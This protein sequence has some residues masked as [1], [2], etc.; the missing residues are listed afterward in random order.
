MSPQGQL[1]EEP[2][3]AKSAANRVSNLVGRGM[4]IALGSNPSQELFHFSAYATSM[5]LFC[6]E[7]E[8]TL[9]W[10]KFKLCYDSVYPEGQTWLPC[11]GTTTPVV[12]FRARPVSSEA[13]QASWDEVEREP[14]LRKATLTPHNPRC[15]CF[16]LQQQADAVHSIHSD[17]SST[18]GEPT[19]PDASASEETP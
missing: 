16:I 12:T 15:E 6:L 3:S 18:E 11:G 13:S 4:A 14:P 5:L 7:G 17:E 1:L 10:E 19:L 8:E 9:S 2:R